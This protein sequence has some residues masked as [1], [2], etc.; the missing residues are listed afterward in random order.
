MQILVNSVAFRQIFSCNL[1]PLQRTKL[2]RRM[3]STL[4]TMIGVMKA[5]DTVHCF[6]ADHPQKLKN[7]SKAATYLIMFCS[8]RCLVAFS[9]YKPCIRSPSHG[10]VEKSSGSVSLNSHALFVINQYCVPIHFVWNFG[11]AIPELYADAEKIFMGL[12][13]PI[14]IFLWTRVSVIRPQKVRRPFSSKFLTRDFN[15]GFRKTTV[16]MPEVSPARSFSIASSSSNKAF[17]ISQKFSIIKCCQKLSFFLSTTFGLYLSFRTLAILTTRSRTELA[18]F[19]GTN[20]W[21]YPSQLS[22]ADYN[23]CSCYLEQNYLLWKTG[24]QWSHITLIL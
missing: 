16:S 17:L 12:A 18:F 10:S 20:E 24:K 13:D 21:M 2:I 23:T 11:T 1:V 5:S 3:V 22:A 14:S 6:P 4:K 15:H 9:N 7:V 8:H 19:L